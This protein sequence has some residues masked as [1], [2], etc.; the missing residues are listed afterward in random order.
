[1]SEKVFVADLVDEAAKIYQRVP[2]DRDSELDILIEIQR[3]PDRKDSVT[4]CERLAKSQSEAV[5]TCAADVLEALSVDPK[6]E[7]DRGTIQTV[8]GRLLDDAAP[9]VATSAIIAIGSWAFPNGDVSLEKFS[10]D[11]SESVRAAVAMAIA[12][13]SSDR[14]LR[15]LLSLA[16][17]DAATVRSW[18][19]FGLGFIEREDR[20]INDCLLAATSDAIDDVRCEAFRCLAERRDLRVIPIL[21][22]YIVHGDEVGINAIEAAELLAD[23]SLYIPLRDLLEWW[24]V[25]PD[26]LRSAIAACANQTD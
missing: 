9:T 18:A 14:A 4:C 21:R 7:I 6:P 22:D 1:M 19:I 13:L 3:H 20:A 5:R 24:D 11:E 8:L 12:S 16:E 25:E 26:L 15:V 2:R 17:D 10:Q 23:P